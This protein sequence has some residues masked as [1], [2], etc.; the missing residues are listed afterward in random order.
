ME[1]QDK[2]ALRLSKIITEVGEFEK[3]EAA[4][5]FARTKNSL[6]ARTFVWLADKQFLE[7]FWDR[8]KGF[9]PQAAPMEK[10]NE[11]V[12]SRGI[13][14]RFMVYQYT[15]KQSVQGEYTLPLAKCPSD[16]Q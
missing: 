16:R 6:L 3:D 14:A 8:I 4:E 9:S 1:R 12:R 13:D 7:N 11:G 2:K 15:E 10:G 5:G